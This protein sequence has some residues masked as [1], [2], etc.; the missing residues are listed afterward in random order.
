MPDRR[1]FSVSVFA[2]HAER[3]LLIRHARLQAWLPVGGEIEPGETPLEAAVRELRE[4]T[5]LA[6]RFERMGGV[7]GTP[8]GLLGYE[9]HLAGSKGIHLNFAFVADVDSDRVVSNGEFGE[10]C[11]IG[12]P[13]GIAELAALS[14]PKN[15]R[16]LAGLALAGGSAERSVDSAS[17]SR[18]TA[19]A[20]EWLAAFNAA[21]LERLLAL[22]ADDAVHLSPK[23]RDRRPETGGLVRGRP[24]LRDWWA[25][26]FA[27]LPGL[28]Y[29]ERTITAMGTAMGT[30]TGTT[31]GSGRIVLEYDRTVPGEA[32]LAVAELFVVRAG[33]I[34]ES[35]VFHG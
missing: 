30:A 10:H 25:D 19:L 35:R 17:C 8:R 33:L 12:G 24:A 27:R 1:A 32:P 21:D 20:R 3:I 15:V 9:E 2:R 34:V 4:E 28:R 16:E 18:L 23:L 26:A 31:D 14:T 22:Y 29:A 6:G 5:G 11:W 7:D 13:T